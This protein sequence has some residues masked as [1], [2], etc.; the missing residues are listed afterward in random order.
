MSSIHS[1]SQ[2]SRN[3]G[4]NFDNLKR[5]SKKL[6]E[7]TPRNYSKR[8]MVR[9]NTNE[10]NSKF[11]IKKLTENFISSLSKGALSFI[12][13]PS[14]SRQD[15]NK[16]LSEEGGEEEGSKFSTPDF[17]SKNKNSNTKQK[18]SPILR[19]SSK[20]SL[21][22]NSKNTLDIEN[23]IK[24][25]ENEIGMFKE[26]LSI[27]SNAKRDLMRIYEN[28]NNP[29]IHYLNLEKAKRLQKIG[30]RSVIIERSRSKLKGKR[31]RSVYTTSKKDKEGRRLRNLE[32]ERRKRRERNGFG[33]FDEFR[34]R[35]SCKLEEIIRGLDD[36]GSAFDREDEDDN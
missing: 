20:S 25:G 14:R 30:R 12:R 33:N 26:E 8:K 29:I 22:A 9:S 27:I 13:S 11:S 34:S 17:K 1:T 2:K 16:M 35:V 31:N 23:G 32:Q 21:V 18:I 28:D 10:K 24:N 15:A 6:R 19:N 4:N 3:H 5:S 7:M 36:A